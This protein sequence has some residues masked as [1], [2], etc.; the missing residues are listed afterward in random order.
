ME[1]RDLTSNHCEP[2]KV[3]S[4]LAGDEYEIRLLNGEIACLSSSTI[5]RN[6]GIGIEAGDWV[7]IYQKQIVYR[8]QGLKNTKNID[9]PQLISQIPAFVLAIRGNHDAQAD[10]YE[11]RVRSDLDDYIRENYFPILDRV[12]ELAQFAKGMQVLDIGIGTGLLTERLPAGLKLFGIDISPKMMEKLVEK[13]LSVELMSGSF[14][15][16]PYA[17]EAFERIISTF[18]FHHLTPDEKEVAFR[19]ID[20]VLKPGGYLVIGDFMFLD[21]EQRTALIEKFSLEGRDD[22]LQELEEEHFTM[23]VDA[24]ASLNSLGYSVESEQGSTISWILRAKKL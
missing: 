12:I 10:N 9:W 1:H 8:W 23:I 15:N 22:M 6:K 16:I 14:T 2:A 18:A 13:K 4:C 21:Q 24:K 11:E 19:E 7:C 3:I 5:L 20:R 17:D